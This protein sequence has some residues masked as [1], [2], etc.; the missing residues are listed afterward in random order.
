MD[1]PSIS[2]REWIE[3]R[4]ASSLTFLAD[5]A[6]SFE[7]GKIGC[8]E[9]GNRLAMSL[10]GGNLS[11]SGNINGEFLKALIYF[12]ALLSEIRSCLAVCDLLKSS[13]AHLVNSFRILDAGRWGCG[14]ISSF[15]I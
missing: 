4:H 6:G 15:R 7:P 11:I 9:L 1:S 8:F 14:M 10:A 2:I 12:F 13:A 5:G 3:G